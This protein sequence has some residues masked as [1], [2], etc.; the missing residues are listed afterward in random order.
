ML[1]F[2]IIT[3]FIKV[4]GSKVNMA[5]RLMMYYAEKLTCDAETYDA[6]RMHLREEDFIQMPYIELKG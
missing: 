6:V 5:A 1:L 3:I 2:I 4:I